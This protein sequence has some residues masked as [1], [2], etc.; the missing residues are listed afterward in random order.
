MRHEEKDDKREREKRDEENR[1]KL[2][3][4]IKRERKNKT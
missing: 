2:T 1:K 3:R 4:I